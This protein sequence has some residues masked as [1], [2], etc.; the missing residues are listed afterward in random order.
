MTSRK[1][2]ARTVGPI[3]RAVEASEARREA[4]WMAARL[5]MMPARW[6]AWLAAEHRRRGGLSSA[7]ANLWLLDATEAGRG[8]VPLAATDEEIRAAAVE[9]AG[10]ASAIAA[11]VAQSPVARKVALLEQHCRRWGIDPPAIG[12]GDPMPA[13]RRMLCARWWLRRLRRAHGRRC[14]GAAIRGGVVR[15]GLWPYASQDAVERRQAQRG[16]NAAALL[17]AVIEDRG[18]GQAVALDQIAAGSVSNPAVRRAELMVRVR[19]IDGFAHGEGWRCEFWTITTPSRYHAQRITGA[20]AEPN[21]QYDHSTPREA[22]HYLSR[23]WARA[24]AAWKRRGLSVVGLRTCEPHHDATPHW[25]V[26]AWGPARDLRFARRLLRVY[27]LRD[28][29]GEPGARAHRFSVK[30]ADGTKAAAYAAAYISKNIDGGGMEGA[31]DQ[32]TGRKMESAV[33]RVDAWASHW[34]IRQFQFFGGPAVGLW[35]ALRKCRESLG[36]DCA[37]ERARIAADASDWNGYWRAVRGGAVVLVKRAADRLTT[38]G[39]RA[40][41]VVIGIAEGARRLV[42]PVRDWVIRWGAAGGAR[43]GG[44]PPRSCG[45]NCTRG[46]VKGSAG[47]GREDE[48]FEILADTVG[49]DAGGGGTGG[50]G[51][52][53]LRGWGLG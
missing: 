23:V 43:A 49:I 39:D 34:G 18:T 13:V 27:A 30:V 14:E 48:L 21:P 28:S 5:G 40:A 12:E 22:Q 20:C 46:A 10:D 51:R 4:A 15:R 37:L 11:V 8:R 53:N 35:R 52:Q 16:R 9:A 2:S 47:R 32:E 38:Y 50:V 36:I 45:N 29:P 33:K 26:I 31:R 17:G 25:H 6:S 24:R 41:D 19:G 3:L 44:S 42:L 1:S 7:L